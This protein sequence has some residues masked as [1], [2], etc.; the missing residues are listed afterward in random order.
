[1]GCGGS[2]AVQPAPE[3]FKGRMTPIP[4]SPVAFEVALGDSDNLVKKHP[5]K[6]IQRLAEQPTSPITHQDIVEKLAEAE[7]RRLQILHQRILSAKQEAERVE[8]AKARKPL[9]SNE[10]Q[11]CEMPPETNEIPAE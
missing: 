8:A 9:M 10:D 2:T 1:M 4:Q 7:A 11:E 5:P 3:A 6:R